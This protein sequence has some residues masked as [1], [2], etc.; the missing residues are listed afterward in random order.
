MV[1]TEAEE[2]RET[3]PVVMLTVFL[4]TAVAPAVMESGDGECD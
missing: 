2:D 1:I 4:I 3:G